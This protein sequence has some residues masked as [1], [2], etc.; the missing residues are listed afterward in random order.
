DGGRARGGRVTRPGEVVLEDASRAF[1]VR[2]D[3]GRTLNGALL[4]RR[5]A[6]PPPVQAL[7]GVSLHIAPGET[8]GM[9]G[10]N[11]AGK[12]STLRVLA[13]IV[14]LDSGRVE[15]GGRVVTLLEL[16]AGFGRDFSGRENIL[17]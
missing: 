5:G 1:S 11:G 8:V 7:D 2:A 12:T 9:V 15:A 10:R 6:G 17:L 16:G 13:G 14:P 3:P 4:G